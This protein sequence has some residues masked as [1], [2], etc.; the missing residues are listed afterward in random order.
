MMEVQAAKLFTLP[1]ETIH[2]AGHEIRARRR[3]CIDLVEACLSHID[4]TDAQV[5]A[6]VLVDRD[7]ARMRAYEL[8]AELAAGRWHGP[9]HGIPVGIKDIVEV[10]GMPT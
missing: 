4:E 2:G 6:W 8:D 7:G 10:A 1:H 3:K 5:H 9:L